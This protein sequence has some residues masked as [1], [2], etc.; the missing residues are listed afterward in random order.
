MIEAVRKDPPDIVGLANYTWNDNVN[1]QIL[2]LIKKE[3]PE[4][5]TLMGGPNFNTFNMENYF[6]NIISRFFLKLFVGSFGVLKSFYK[7]IIF[8]KLNFFRI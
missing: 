3:F 7:I 5:I 6:L 1:A 2:K 4:I 8:R